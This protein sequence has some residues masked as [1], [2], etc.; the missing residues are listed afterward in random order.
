MLSK[1]LYALG[2]SALL[3]LGL[4]VPTSQAEIGISINVGD[5]PYYHGPSYYDSGYQYVWVPGYERDHQWQRGHYQRKGSYNAR[6]KGEK[7]K[8]KEEHHG[9]RHKKHHDKD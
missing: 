5:R 7:F 9:K 3:A 6:Y 2:A 8:Y 4:P 1:S